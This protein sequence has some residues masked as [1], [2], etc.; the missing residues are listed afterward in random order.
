MRLRYLA[1]ALLTVAIGLGVHLGGSF[2]PPQIR[3]VAGDALWAAMMVWWVSALSPRSHVAVR[4][5]V[6]LGISWIVELSQLY[7]TPTLD[8]ARATTIGGLILGSGFDARDLVAYAAGV[9]AAVI[10]EAMVRRR[11][12]SE[13]A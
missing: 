11:P 13:I 12:P 4:A 3:D 7:H 2:I 9:F 10:I 5:G 8:A 6:A 1:A